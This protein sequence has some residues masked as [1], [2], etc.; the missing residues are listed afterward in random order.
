LR[1][2]APLRGPEGPIAALDSDAVD[3]MF[4]SSSLLAPIRCTLASGVVLIR[5][6]L[7]SS[8]ATGAL[9]ESGEDRL[10]H[11]ISNRVEKEFQ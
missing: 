2:T 7:A 9:A 11:S 1:K 3:A 6:I 8:T 5:S 10:G 4:I